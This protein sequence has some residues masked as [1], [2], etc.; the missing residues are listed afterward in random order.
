VTVQC[1]N[2]THKIFSPQSKKVLEIEGIQSTCCVTYSR[3][4]DSIKNQIFPDIDRTKG[5]PVPKN[6]KTKTRQNTTNPRY[7]SLKNSD[8]KCS[9][10]TSQEAKRQEWLKN[11][12]FWR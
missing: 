7:A 1:V 11:K 4:S 8:T 12:S 6:V 9:I 3:E 5:V 10:I 2:I